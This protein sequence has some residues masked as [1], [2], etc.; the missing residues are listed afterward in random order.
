MKNLNYVVR[1]VQVDREDYGTHNYQRYLQYAVI[2]YRELK[3]HVEHNISVAYL[4]PNDALI[5]PLPMDF[6]D[7][8]RIGV[9]SNGVILNLGLNQDLVLIRNTNDCGVEVADAANYEIQDGDDGWYYPPH[10][11]NGIYT[12]KL[13]GAGG[14][15]SAQGYYR[16]DYERNQIMFANI[17]SSEIILE[18]VS[19]GSDASDPGS[20][21][22]PTDAANV[23]RAYVNW[24]VT[25]NDKRSTL[26][27]RQRRED[28]Y[29]Y[30]YTMYRI[31]KHT[32][33][34]QEYLDESYESYSS[35]AKR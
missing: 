22:I 3:L 16:I 30:A 25:E 28:Q 5:A 35:T 29:N 6:S 18:Y 4:T 24:Q 27:E 13:Y 12:D 14:G 15:F 31:R 20:I 10:Y 21:L 11:R 19:D 32:P 7:Y 8:V 33:T 2:G 1:I 26:G 9:A 34:L 17:R 23:V